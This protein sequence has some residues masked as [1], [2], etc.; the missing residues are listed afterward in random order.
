[1]KFCPCG[2]KIS[3]WG[4]RK[5]LR[6]GQIRRN[7]L[8]SRVDA[9]ILKRGK[10]SI[11]Y[12]HAIITRGLYTFYLLF[13][14]YSC[15]VTFA[16]CMVIIQEQFLIKSGLQRRA[17]GMYQT[18]DIHTPNLETMSPELFTCD[19]SFFREIQLGYISIQIRS[20]QIANFVRKKEIK[21]CR[22][23]IGYWMSWSRC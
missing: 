20:K 4:V 23:R 7:K 14:V 8:G 16:L 12:T 15:T 17:Q 2:N 11:Y 6:D 18:H 5:R 21:I 13:E 10:I 9:F 22:F 3:A 1:M 19:C